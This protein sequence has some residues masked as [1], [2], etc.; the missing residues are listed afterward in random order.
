MATAY[1]KDKDGNFTSTKTCSD[2]LLLLSLYYCSPSVLK[3][4]FANTDLLG[5]NRASGLF[6]G[7]F[8]PASQRPDGTWRKARRVKDGYVP[9]EEV[10]LYESKG[11]KFV[12]ARPPVSFVFQSSLR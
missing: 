3:I 6:A 12:A 2:R 4:Y 7:K 9:Q 10:P 8:I 1:E 11:K 5:L